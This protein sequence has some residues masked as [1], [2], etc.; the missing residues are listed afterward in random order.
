LSS[1][2]KSRLATWKDTLF[3]KSRNGIVYPSLHCIRRLHRHA[4]YFNLK[5][6]DDFLYLDLLNQFL[7]SSDLYF[8]YGRDL[9]RSLQSTEI[10]D[11]ALNCPL[12]QRADERFFWN[13][14][15]LVKLMDLARMP[16]HGDV[17]P[18]LTIRFLD[19]SCLL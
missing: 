15:L 11:F 2:I 8:S 4:L 10:L 1:E 6:Q 9:T 18:D 7:S 13:S 5:K 16:E 14:Y 3:T 12:W 17:I 19:L